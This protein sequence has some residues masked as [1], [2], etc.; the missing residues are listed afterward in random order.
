MVLCGHM[1]P[2]RTCEHMTLIGCRIPRP[3]PPYDS[4]RACRC[5]VP[6][7]Q[8][9]RWNDNGGRNRNRYKEDVK[10]KRERLIA[11]S[12]LHSKNTHR[13]TITYVPSPPC[14][15]QG[16]P[17]KDPSATQG[18]GSG[19]QTADRPLAQGAPRTERRQHSARTPRRVRTSTH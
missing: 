9:S 15:C 5:T 11:F 17:R 10:F 14:L 1:I 2:S 13:N 18:K 4:T 16:A 8:R 3:A 12:S 6:F 7:T 19:G